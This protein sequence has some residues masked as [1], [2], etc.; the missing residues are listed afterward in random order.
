MADDGLL[1]QEEVDALTSGL[2][3]KESAATGGFERSTIARASD[4]FLN[5]ARTV[6]S[7]NLGDSLKIS[8]SGTGY[9]DWARITS[10]F[11]ESLIIESGFDKGFEGRLQFL[12]GKQTAARLGALML[13]SEGEPAYAEE[14]R[15]AVSELCNQWMGSVSSAL[16]K[17]YDVTLS[18]AQCKTRDFDPAE[19][20]PAPK[21]SVTIDYSLQING[22]D[23]GR[24]SLLI[25]QPLVVSFTDSTA[26][27]SGPS[28]VEDQGF[29]AAFPD[30]A[31]PEATETWMESSVA[32]MDTSGKNSPNIQMLMDIGLNVTIELGRT[33]LS[34]RR[35]L[36]LGPGSIVEMDRLAGEPVDLLVNDKVVA[37]GE[38]VV[39]DEYFGIRIISLVSPEE[40]IR[41]LQ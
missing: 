36:E 12:I 11:P 1:S 8:E 33:N 10:D 7:A 38:V 5:E 20:G 13:G 31:E 41:Q 22:A 39:V 14:H 37:K 21:G 28:V 23:A 34:I 35:I 27:G 18:A 16:G 6:L 24:L 19:M 15:D 26:S 9:A 17:S 32:G 2:L 25:S 4:T 3:G 29:P 30:S 40:R